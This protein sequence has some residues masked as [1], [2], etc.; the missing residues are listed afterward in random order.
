MF[1]RYEKNLRRGFQFGNDAVLVVHGHG[2]VGNLGQNYLGK[3]L[4]MAQ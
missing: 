3:F 1:H 4:V 2:D